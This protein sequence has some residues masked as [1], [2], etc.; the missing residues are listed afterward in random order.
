MA[1]KRELLHKTAI[2]RKGT[3]VASDS[4]CWKRNGSCYIRQPL[5]EKEQEL[6][7]T[8]NDGKET[9]VLHQTAVDRKGTRVASDS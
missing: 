5:I 4:K 1:K 6:H 3:R 2:D 7:Q 8:V 9:G